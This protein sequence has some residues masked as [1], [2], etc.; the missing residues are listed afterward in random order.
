[1]LLSFSYIKNPNSQEKANQQGKHL[2]TSRNR[3]GEIT[4]VGNTVFSTDTLNKLLG[5]KSGDYFS[6]DDLS[7][8]LLEGDVPTRYFD[9]GNVFFKADFATS[10]KPNREYDIAITVYEGIKGKIGVV[11]VIGNKSISDGDILQNVTIKTGDLFNRTKIV[12]SV[13]AIG[14]IGKFIPEKIDVHVN[15]QGTLTDDGYAIINLEF[16]VVE[17]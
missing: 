4:W 15:P 11:S 1:M 12:K 7:K 17:K 9:N 2:V 16:V 10:L 6:F 8:R 13:K 5:L 3:I 14:D